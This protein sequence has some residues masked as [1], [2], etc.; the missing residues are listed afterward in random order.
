MDTTIAI[1]VNPLV[2]A[3]IWVLPDS[4]KRA[5]LIGS[6]AAVAT[7]RTKHDQQFVQSV[8]RLLHLTTNEQALNAPVQMSSYIWSN[9]ENIDLEVD[10][11]EHQMLKD[12]ELRECAR[13]VAAS[14]PEWF[15]YD[16]RETVAGE[17]LEL[18]QHRNELV[19][20]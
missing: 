3:F 1:K 13:R 19:F 6:L 12:A 10:A 7:K 9:S 14:I 18:F 2:R 4:A 5:L 20:T 16:D 17:I 15:L 11:I 8:N